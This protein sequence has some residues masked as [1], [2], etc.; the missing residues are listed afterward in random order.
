M[1]HHH[2]LISRTFFL[3]A[4]ALPAFAQP[5][6]PDPHGVLRKP[7]PDKIVVLTFDDGPA[8]GYTVVAPIL[9][10][11]GFNGSFYVCDFDCEAEGTYPG[12]LRR[13]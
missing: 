8:S 6:D 7:I 12:R 9:K 1:L 2:L 5:A 13:V 4:L 11:L 3:A 10:P